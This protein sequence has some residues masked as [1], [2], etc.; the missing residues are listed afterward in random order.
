[1]GPR[2]KWASGRRTLNSKRRSLARRDHEG[3]QGVA[4]RSDAAASRHHLRLAGGYVKVRIGPPNTG[5]TKTRDARGSSI[6]DN[7]QALVS[8][9]EIKRNKSAQPFSVLC[10]DN[11][12]GDA[13]GDGIK[14]HTLDLVTDTVDTNGVGPQS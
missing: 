5:L 8:F 10:L 11:Q 1:V 14:Y 13:L 4:Q 7:A 12:M 2:T 6:S 9:D 3:G